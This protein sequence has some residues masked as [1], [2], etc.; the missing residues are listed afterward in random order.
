MSL[1]ITQ[2]IR[3]V[4][5]GAAVGDALGMPLEFDLAS[6]PQNLIREMHAGRLPAGS[7]T[8]DTEMALAL[9]ESLLER[10]QL[11]PQ[12]LSNR[13]MDWY[14]RRPADVGIHTT[15]VLQTIQKGQSWQ[16]AAVKVQSR[17]P[18]SAGN[19]SVMRCWPVAVMCWHDEELLERWS[20][21]QSQ[22]THAHEECVA[23]CNFVNVMIARM[24][25]GATPTAAYHESLK[26]VALPD[27]LRQVIRMAPRRKR[28]ELR[29]TGWVRHTIESALWGLLNT[30]TFEDALVQVINLGADADTAG[31]VA[32]ALAGAAYG[33]DEIPESWKK[34]LRG[35]WPLHSGAIWRL[36]DFITMADRLSG[37]LGA[38][39]PRIPLNHDL[40]R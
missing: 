3:G 19:G 23:G 37:C 5:V 22:V 40:T 6:P 29:N 39:L 35:E 20:R 12:D 33:V 16:E 27:G 34:M 18:D 36:P 1:E 10:C 28:E 38:N 25:N 13:F 17:Y 14:L 2:R 26:M 9:A 24:V 31:T 32:G 7:F 8:D 4:A 21:L 15:N 11:D 30:D